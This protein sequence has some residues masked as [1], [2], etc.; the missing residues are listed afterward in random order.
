MF[1]KSETGYIR[2]T[3]TTERPG[4]SLFNPLHAKE[5]EESGRLADT[6]E[7]ETIKHVLKKIKNDLRQQSP[8]KTNAGKNEC[9]S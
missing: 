7:E 9:L 2:T 4:R 8:R 6:E 1:Y 5:L 3:T